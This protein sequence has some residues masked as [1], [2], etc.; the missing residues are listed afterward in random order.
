M[1]D[2]RS[3][4][5]VA[6]LREIAREAHTSDALKDAARLRDAADELERLREALKPFAAIA[7]HIERGNMAAI[8]AREDYMYRVRYV[9]GESAS[10]RFVDCKRAAEVLK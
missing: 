4:E 3:N 8:M 1:N 7:D 5:V 10:L 6:F 2:E 9:V